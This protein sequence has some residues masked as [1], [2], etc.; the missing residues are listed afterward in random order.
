MAS[1]VPVH[2][3]WR[4]AVLAALA[5]FFASPLQAQQR[6][7]SPPQ[8]PGQAP[9]PQVTWEGLPRMQLEQM[10][11]G[12]LQDTVV[13]RWRDPQT[14]TLCYLYVPFTVQHSDKTPTGAVQYGPNNIG[15]ISCTEPA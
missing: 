5:A 11:A 3:A 13:Q 6:P 2:Q 9:R 1:E 4:V 10:F 12:P 7:P 15:S 8:Q 14:G